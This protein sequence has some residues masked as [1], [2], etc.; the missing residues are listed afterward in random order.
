MATKQDLQGWLIEALTASMGSAKLVDIA[1]H[2][3]KHHEADLRRSGD[4]L[5]TWQYDMRWA[6]NVLRRK[7]ILRSVSASPRGIWEL[8]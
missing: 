4:L 2:M 5:Y 1:R 3:W 7:G 6:A 8:A